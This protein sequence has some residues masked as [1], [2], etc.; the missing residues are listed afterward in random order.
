MSLLDWIVGSR[1]NY[2]FSFVA[3]SITAVFFLLWGVFAYTGNWVSCAVAMAIGAL[4]WGLLEY[5]GH[6]WFFHLPGSPAHK[7]HMR[8]HDEPAEFLAMPWFATT[9]VAFALWVVLRVVITDGP[10]SFYMAALMAG[11]ISYGTLHHV[12]HHININVLPGKLLKSSWANH[13][14][15]H[16]MPGT[17]YGVTTTLWDRIFGTH[18]QSRRQC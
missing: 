12:Y 6:R 9:I 2:W 1:L 17:N 16:K 15:H 7:G 8:H 14:I 4:S 10:A 5:S 18:Y 13:K 3:D 11:Y